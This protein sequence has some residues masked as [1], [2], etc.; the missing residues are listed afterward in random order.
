[1]PKF[2]LEIFLA[3]SQT[4]AAGLTHSPR[5]QCDDGGGGKQGNVEVF[6]RVVRKCRL[7]EDVSNMDLKVALG[8]VTISSI[9]KS[10]QRS[11]V[12]SNC[13]VAVQSVWMTCT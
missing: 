13:T 8:V 4:Q 3:E 2:L 12:A 11:G 6:E 7:G 9:Y 5:P 10:W 1:M